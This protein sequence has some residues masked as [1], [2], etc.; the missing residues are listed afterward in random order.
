MLKTIFS[1]VKKLLRLPGDDAAKEFVQTFSN[2]IEHASQSQKLK[3]YDSSGSSGSD[4]QLPVGSDYFPNIQGGLGTTSPHGG[5]IKSQVRQS[6]FNSAKNPNLARDLQ[7]VNST[8]QTELSQTPHKIVIK[9]NMH[10]TPGYMHSTDVKAQNQI[11]LSGNQSDIVHMRDSNQQNPLQVN[12]IDQ[13]FM[14]TP[15]PGG[16]KTSRRNKSHFSKTA[17][18]QMMHLTPGAASQRQSM[19][20]PAYESAL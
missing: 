14:T 2:K 6:P 20:K 12:G 15:G 9:G 5:N 17:V 1:L 3:M 10:Q 7:S 11:R 13:L 4:I 8:D 19:V 18:D 16:S